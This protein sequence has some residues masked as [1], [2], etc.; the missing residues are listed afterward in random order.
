M[1]EE[2]N[3]ISRIDAKITTYNKNDVGVLLE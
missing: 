3:A 2:I 1:L